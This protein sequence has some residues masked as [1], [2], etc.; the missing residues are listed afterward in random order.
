MAHLSKDCSQIEVSFLNGWITVS[1]P[2]AAAQRWAASDEVGMQGVY[3]GVTV[4]VE[5]DFSCLHGG[6]AENEDKFPNPAA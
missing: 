1:L 3:R 4:L 2:E 5:K 6:A